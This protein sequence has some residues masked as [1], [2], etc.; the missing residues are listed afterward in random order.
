M[1]R[2]SDVIERLS[3]VE[4]K[5]DA[6]MQCMYD[7]IGLVKVKD[8]LQAGRCF[9]DS[10]NVGRSYRQASR[11]RPWKK[12]RTSADSARNGVTQGADVY[13]CDICGSEELLTQ[14][15]NC[16]TKGCYKDQFWCAFKACDNKFCRPCQMAGPCVLRKNSVSMGCQ[17]HVD[18]A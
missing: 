9:V 14:C 16:D 7:L 1:H 10:D 5:V 3:T 6:S 8:E 15:V 4:H 13:A 12:R 17:E 11:E 18:N 2:D